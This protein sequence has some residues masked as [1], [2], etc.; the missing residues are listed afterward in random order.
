MQI[1]KQKYDC[2]LENVKWD[3]REAFPDFE[4]LPIL[5]QFTKIVI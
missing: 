3:S 1:K 4:A 2:K 5:E